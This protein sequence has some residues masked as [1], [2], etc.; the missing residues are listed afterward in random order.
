MYSGY[1]NGD[2]FQVGTG[3]SSFKLIDNTGACLPGITTSAVPIFSLKFGVNFNVVCTC[4]GCS[5][6]IPLFTQ[7]MGKTVARYSQDTSE[8]VTIP[9]ISDTAMT[10]LQLVF[11]VGTYGS[12]KFKY[13]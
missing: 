7:F 6:S 1:K 9:T 12:Q 3:S 13:I 10:S 8:N 11:V 5:S 4:S 2:L